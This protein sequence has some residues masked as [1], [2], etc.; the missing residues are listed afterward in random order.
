MDVSSHPVSFS[1]LVGLLLVGGLSSRMGSGSHKAV[2]Q[3]CGQ[4]LYQKQ[5]QHMKKFMQIILIALRQ[6]QQHLFTTAAT[7]PSSSPNNQSGR[8]SLL[9]DNVDHY[10]ESGPITALL[11]ANDRYPDSAL[12]VFACD[13]PLVT[14]EAFKQ[15]IENYQ[16]PLTCFINQ[17]G[18]PEPLFS[19][20][21]TEALQRLRDNYEQQKQTGPIYT[22]RQIIKMQQQQGYDNSE[23]SNRTEPNDSTS[24]SGSLIT[25]LSREWLF[26][27]NTALEWQQALEIRR[28]AHH[29]R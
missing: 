13:F 25:P 11:T 12:L 3:W 19:I 29:Q 14:D 1:S 16:H 17:D 15:L 2:M 27:T 23:N 21:S 26:N 7:D 22:I 24:T 6:E 9:F 20:W 10:G 8:V 5:I 4:P 18:Y 28:N